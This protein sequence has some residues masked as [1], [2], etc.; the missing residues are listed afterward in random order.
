[1]DIYVVQSGDTVNSIA[2]SYGVSP[3]SILI[4]NGITKPELLVVGQALLILIPEISHI[5]KQGETLEQIAEQ[6]GVSKLD[7]IQNNPVLV[8]KNNVTIGQELVISYE[9]QQDELIENTGFVYSYVEP[10]V[11]KASLPYLTYVIIF[12]Y[13]FNEDGTI[14]VPEDKFIRDLAEEYDTA[15]L[16]SLTTIEENGN[17]S[18][19]KARQLLT[20]KEL[21]EKV[22]DNMI[23]VIQ[24]KGAKGIDID[25]EFIPPELK[26]EYID[27]IRLAS[28]KMN[29][30]GYIVNVDLAPKTSA[31]QMGTLYEAHDYEAI[32][33]LADTVFLMT[34]EWGYTFSEPRA[35]APIKSVQTVVDYALTEIEPK[36]MYLGIPN[37]G[38]DWPLPY[39]KGITRATTIGNVTAVERAQKYGAEIQYDEDSQT[40]YFTYTAEDGTRHEVWFED[41]R[42]IDKKFDIIEKD[43]LLGG[44]YWNLMRPFPQNWMLLNYRFKPQKLI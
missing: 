36:K 37:Y 30:Q 5:V 1:M 12:E 26:E 38:Y 8:G 40:P 10:D 35:V 32:G 27:F 11:L 6:Y 24:A 33:E 28:D 25:F 4:N 20:N 31:S 34:Y 18:S 39:R 42:S 2:E 3:E 22:L 7:V 19:D 23:N 41:V 16:L 43:N 21:Q 14:I 15:V 29:A 17:F 9:G 13:G 44:G